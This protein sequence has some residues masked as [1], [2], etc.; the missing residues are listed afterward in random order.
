M[1]LPKA[2][3]RLPGDPITPLRPGQPGCQF[4][5]TPPEVPGSTGLPVVI[6]N[7]GRLFSTPNSYAQVS[8]LQPPGWQ[9]SEKTRLKTEGSSPKERQQAMGGTTWLL[10]ARR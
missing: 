6:I 10:S 2:A 5:E 9:R 7:G 4:G 3:F 1:L 8:A